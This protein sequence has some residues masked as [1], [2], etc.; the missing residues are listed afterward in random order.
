MAAQDNHLAELEKQLIHQ[1]LELDQQASSVLREPVASR[2]PVPAEKTPPR[3][4]LP[5]WK[6]SP[7]SPSARAR[8]EV[9]QITHSSDQATGG[10]NGRR[11][12]R[13]SSS[14]SS[15]K[16]SAHS[17]LK[18]PV[19]ESLPLETQV[20]ML[21]S[22]LRVA[23]AEV[24]ALQAACDEWKGR[25]EAQDAAHAR[26]AAS[27]KQRQAD[28]AAH[29]KRAEA[30][31]HSLEKLQT[32]NKALEAELSALRQELSALRKSSK[33]ADAGSSALQARLQRALEE[34][35]VLKEENARLKSSLVSEAPPPS[36][37]ESLLTASAASTALV[38][39]DKEMNPLNSSSCAMPIAICSG[40][41]PR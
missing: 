18:T 36:P 4:N 11:A 23:S 26:V 1:D 38:R 31:K 35:S 29:K 27:L 5:S 32:S 7:M 13:P 15:K 30:H 17:Q 22:Q 14:S 20:K 25:C 33:S 24:G 16:Q 39:R 9:A 2:L 10:D 6:A 34:R 19:D 41:K 40:R 12:A 28:A 3:S 8:A 21:R 37:S